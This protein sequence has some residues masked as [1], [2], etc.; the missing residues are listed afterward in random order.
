MKRYSA[1]FLVVVMACGL[2][3]G[4]FF[5]AEGVK[6]APDGDSLAVGE[7]STPS[8]PSAGE[9]GL[10]SSASGQTSGG[11]KL[12]VPEGYTLARIGMTLEEAGI[13]TTQE[14]VDA[15]QNGDYSG[16]SLIA[17][18]PYNEHRCFTL[19]GYLFPATYEFGANVSLDEIIRTLLATTES[20]LVA[21]SADIEASGYSTDEI[22]TL[23]SVI[24][25]ESFGTEAMA[26]VSSVFH[27]RL[28]Q[29]M[30][31]QSDPTINYVEGAIKP[32]ITGDVD[33]YN[34]YYNT[35]KCP[36]LPAGPI[37]NPGMEAINA[38][39]HPAST[40]Y[41]YFLTDADNNYH[42]AEDFEGHKANR[43]KT[44]V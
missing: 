40:N 17:A 34:E 29:G 32:F 9:D 7:S 24:Q 14:F 41:L 20:R 1:F 16:Y 39:L 35:Y 28:A 4:C 27:N 12:V 43:E 23:A 3:T 33:R 26:M 22:L 15:T 21:V 37:C 2:L 19:E 30:P 11:F 36:A 18:Q 42:F 6:P 5:D 38:A 44:G 10:A 31:L 25:K 8:V 13:C